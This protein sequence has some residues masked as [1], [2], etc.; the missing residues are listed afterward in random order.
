MT[1]LLIILNI[2]RSHKGL[3]PLLEVYP[4]M[5][6]REDIGFESRCNRHAFVP[7]N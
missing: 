1:E 4:E 3:S 6:L 2:V 5:R 7:G